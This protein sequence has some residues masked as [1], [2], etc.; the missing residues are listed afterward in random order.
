M[1][2]PRIISAGF[3]P[4]THGFFCLLPYSIDPSLWV[5]SPVLQI[6]RAGNS[7]DLLPTLRPGLWFHRW[8]QVLL[9]K[10][11]AT[12]MVCLLLPL[13]GGLPFCPAPRR[14]PWIVHSGGEHDGRI[15]SK[16]RRVY[17]VRRGDQIK[18]SPSRYPRLT[19]S[20]RVVAPSLLRIEL[21]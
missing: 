21:T 19:A 4:I 11:R 18:I 15:A 14:P 7:T 16:P 20:V 1:D 17:E 2:C 3:Q 8:F 5:D 12:R 9:D 6:V 10:Q 13:T